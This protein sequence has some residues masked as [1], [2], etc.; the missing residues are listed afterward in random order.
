MTNHLTP[1]QYGNYYEPHDDPKHHPRCD[2]TVE[3]RCEE[4]R[5]ADEYENADTK[6][7]YEKEHSFD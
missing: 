2:P 5:R 6:I 1:A 3:C 7:A 4:E